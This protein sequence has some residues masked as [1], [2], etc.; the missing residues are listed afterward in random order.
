MSFLAAVDPGP[1]R[2]AF[3]ELASVGVWAG[4]AVGCLVALLCGV[5]LARAVM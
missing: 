5:Y 4:V 2:E 1:T 3:Y